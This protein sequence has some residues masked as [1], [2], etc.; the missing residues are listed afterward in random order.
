MVGIVRLVYS[1]DNMEFE[2][3]YSWQ[4]KGDERLLI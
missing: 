2:N 4:V 1:E 3:V